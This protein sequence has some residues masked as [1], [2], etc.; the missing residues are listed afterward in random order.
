MHWQQYFTLILGC[1][2]TVGNIVGLVSGK[3]VGDRVTAL[4][5]LAM[6]LGFQ[7]I[8]WSGGWYN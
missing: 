1:T 3:T 6:V 4:V 7:C 5:A 8:L 2:G